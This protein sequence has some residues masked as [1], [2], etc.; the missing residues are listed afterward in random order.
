MFPMKIFNLIFLYLVIT[1][2]MSCTSNLR[3]DNIKSKLEPSSNYGRFLS[4]RYLLKKGNN[5]IASKIISKSQNLNLD[6]T[7]AELNFKSYLINGDFERN[8]SLPFLLCFLESSSW[9]ATVET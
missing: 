7:L 6:L 4:T 9:L 5:D 3:V 1:L 8:A 2:F